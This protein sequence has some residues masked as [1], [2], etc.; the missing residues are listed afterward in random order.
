M[1]TIFGIVIY[2]GI[3]IANDG[4]DND[5]ENNHDNHGDDKNDQGD[6]TSF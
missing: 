1:S 5:G 3:D 2:N 4:T 6:K